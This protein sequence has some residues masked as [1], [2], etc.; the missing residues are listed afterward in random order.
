[1]YIIYILCIY[2]VY[3]ID[4]PP[5]LKNIFIEALHISVYEI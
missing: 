4:Q 1:M 2:N 5:F 3:M